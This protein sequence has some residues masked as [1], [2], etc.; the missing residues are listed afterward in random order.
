MEDDPRGLSAL[1]SA[2]GGDDALLI[3]EGFPDDHLAVLEDGGC[4]AEDEID[5][6]GDGAVTVKLAVGVGVEC[7]LVAVHLA[8]VEN[9]LIRL[10]SE[11][12]GLVFFRSGGVFESHVFG[13]ESRT[14]HRCEISR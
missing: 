7:I 9:G 6:A 3:F 12:H 2:L 1:R 8:V 13:H 4:V 14:D 11:G 5:G 10:N